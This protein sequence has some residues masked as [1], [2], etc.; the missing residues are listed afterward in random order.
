MT[1]NPD[2]SWLPPI[3]RP[4]PPAI[5]SSK[6]D[7]DIEWQPN[8]N[9][10]LWPFKWV[11]RRWTA[12][13]Q[14]KAPKMIRGNQNYY[15]TSQPGQQDSYIVDAGGVIANFKVEDSFHPKPIPPSGQW[16]FS[17]SSPVIFG[18]TIPVPYFAIT[19]KTFTFYVGMRWSE[20]PSERY[21][22]LGAG[23]KRVRKSEAEK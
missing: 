14:G 16:Q 5:W 23:F 17:L 8:H 21:Y 11:P 6:T 2:Y 12:F 13:P 1:Q 22:N 7:K 20:G 3:H 4:Y 15:N 10:W 9:D 19:F 18:K